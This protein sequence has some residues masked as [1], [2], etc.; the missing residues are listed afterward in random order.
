MT[1]L[2]S[3]IN[4]VNGGAHIQTQFCQTPKALLF[5][6]TI[7]CC[8]QNKWMA[9]VTL[10]GSASELGVWDAILLGPISRFCIT[11]FL[12][13]HFHCFLFQKV[14]SGIF[15]ATLLDRSD[16]IFLLSEHDWKS[17]ERLGGWKPHHWPSFLL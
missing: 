11:V 17:K 5:I 3:H 13:S 4:Q 15:E 2:N 1:C 14:K 7:P 8:L 16:G 6:I 9:A 10:M 12:G